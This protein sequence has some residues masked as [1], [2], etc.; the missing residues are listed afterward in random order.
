VL[1]L[2]RIGIVGQGE[3]YRWSQGM[4]GVAEQDL[5]NKLD[6]GLTSKRLVDGVQIPP[7]P[8]TGYTEIR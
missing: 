5:D 1:K 2:C 7:P 6:L 4:E 8:S 3:G